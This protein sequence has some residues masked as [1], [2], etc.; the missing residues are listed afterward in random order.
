[1]PDTNI[2]STATGDNTSTFK[3]YSVDPQELDRAVDQK[4][5]K[6]FNQRWGHQL[7]YYKT[8]PELKAAIDAKA[9]WTVGKGFKSNPITEMSL[10]AIK[11]F[12]KD[13]FNS[14]IEKSKPLRVAITH[15]AREG[16]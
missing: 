8:I 4:E 3:D 2:S 15:E 5:T 6:Y 12:R 10:S 13:T 1:M 16:R 11:G 14:I 9:R 7:G